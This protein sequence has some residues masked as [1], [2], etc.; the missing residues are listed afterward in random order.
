MLFTVKT[1]FVTLKNHFICK[2]V[3]S[4]NPLPYHVFLTFRSRSPQNLHRE[5][6]EDVTQSLRKRTWKPPACLIFGC[7]W[8]LFFSPLI[9]V[10][11]F[12]E[13]GLSSLEL[14]KLATFPSTFK[15]CFFSPCPF[16]STLHPFV[17][18]RY[19]SLSPSTLPIFPLPLLFHP[20]AET[21]PIREN[22]QLLEFAHRKAGGGL[23]GRAQCLP[24]EHTNR[25]SPE[26]LRRWSKG[27]A[28]KANQFP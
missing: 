22:Q 25:L 6:L 3:L 26:R 18:P 14:Y 13:R 27:R 9:K 2:P 8:Q 23:G 7:V 10:L 17:Q 19:L 5:L 15:T 21:A 16:S 20:C 24:P 4:F 1:F 28:Q 11:G 12:F